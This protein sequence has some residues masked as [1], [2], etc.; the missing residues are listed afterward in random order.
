MGIPS[1]LSVT[2]CCTSLKGL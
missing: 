2:R 1:L